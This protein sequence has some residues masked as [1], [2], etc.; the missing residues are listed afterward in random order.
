M[1]QR[2]AIIAMSLATAALCFMLAEWTLHQGIFENDDAA[3]LFQANV[4]A[5]GRLYANPP[6]AV[7]YQ[8]L[9]APTF[10]WL[11]MPQG[12]WIAQYHFGNSLLLSIGVLLGSAWLIPAALSGAT[13]FLIHEIVRAAHDAKTALVA[14]LMACISPALLGVG[15]TLFSENT[16]RFCLAAFILGLLKTLQNLDP[17]ERSRSWTWALM[18]GAGLGYTINTRPLTAVAFALAGALLVLWF[19]ASR[20]LLLAVLKA[21]IPFF[22][23]LILFIGLF[24][25]WNSYFTGDP[26][27]STYTMTEMGFTES[28]TPAD[29]YTR[30]WRKLLPN[31]LLH[32]TGWG[33]LK[34]DP[35]YNLLPYSEGS[36]SGVYFRS[37]ST[38]DWVTLYAN[39]SKEGKFFFVAQAVNSSGKAAYD[40]TFYFTNATGGRLKGKFTIRKT[41]G[42]FQASF[43]QKGSHVTW[44][45]EE[46]EFELKE[47]IAAGIVAAAPSWL[48]DYKVHFSNPRLG[49]NVDEL[50]AVSFSADG[51]ISWD[52]GSVAP[53]SWTV[54]KD[55]T[56]D[57]QPANNTS[58]SKTF[59]APT[60]STLLQEDQNAFSI[61]FESNS[62]DP[63]ISLVTA[64][65]LQLKFAVALF[66]LLATSLLV[67]IPVLRWKPNMYDVFFFSIFIS[68]ALLYGF[69]AFDFWHG[70]VLPLRSRYYNEAILLG[71]IPLAARSIV[72]V[73]RNIFAI[74]SKF[75]AAILTIVP[76]AF[77]LAANFQAQSHFLDLYAKMQNPDGAHWLPPRLAKEQGLSNAVV[78]IPRNGESSRA[79]GDFPAHSVEK[80]NVGMIWLDK[81]PGWEE[82]YR[83]HF[84]GRKP[85]LFKDRSLLPLKLSASSETKDSTKS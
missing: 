63:S 74:P 6:P 68:T 76:L 13:V 58:F 59:G 33:P 30:F 5:S 75:L 55:G 14:A 57:S 80:A 34:P 78:F 17:S 60:L 2:Q 67:L 18:S 15:I 70:K 20:R 22:A 56:I 72:I 24:F 36:A 32:T 37:I 79:S 83:A 40:E 38:G 45:S 61:D 4:F 11:T 43:K 42:G 47:P 69:N 50:S 48:G 16:S 25:G 54:R 49:P 23:A 51:A 77:G 8:Y 73:Y 10:Y 85:Y 62:L 82:L 39:C 9:F 64:Q 52:I 3:Y 41:N 28:H 53:E 66:G 27:K 65:Q 7:D 21:F 26:L 35:F 31:I 12:K 71:L 81:H 46:I 84:R 19:M 29:A 1:T 44:Q